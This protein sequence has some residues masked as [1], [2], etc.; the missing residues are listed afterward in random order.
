MLAF[1][2]PV[3]IG[4]DIQAHG[5]SCVQSRRI[6]K[7]GPY[8]IEQWLARKLPASSFQDGKIR[9]WEHIRSVLRGIVQES[10]WQ[11][12]A[13]AIQLPGNLVR[14]QKM[15]IPEGRREQAILQ[16][17]KMQVE[18][19]FGV[20]D[21]LAIDFHVQSSMVHYVV[22]RMDYIRQYV[23]CINASGLKVKRVDVDLYVLRRLFAQVDKEVQAIFFETN[24]HA[25]L[26]IS[27]T[28]EILFHHQWNMETEIISEMENRIQKILAMFP[29]KIK[30]LLFYGQHKM[31]LSE[32]WN[33]EYADPF[34]LMRFK[35]DMQ[36]ENAGDYL[37]ACGLAMSEVAKR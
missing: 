27:D 36:P 12:M 29:G 35:Q 23:D 14:M 15:R 18:R 8:L 9:N 10:G 7:N 5:I 19:D 31:N 4:L 6:R 32:E 11:G 24:K 37:L 22:S 33:V 28:H 1:F 26:V 16:E 34:S 30:K 17:I 13:V 21:E 2:S 20:R 25:F 3:M